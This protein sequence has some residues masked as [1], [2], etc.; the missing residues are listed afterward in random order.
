ME[1]TKFD[2]REAKD[3]NPDLRYIEFFSNEHW[4]SGIEDAINKCV[5]L[6]KLSPKE[7]VEIAWSVIDDISR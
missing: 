6:G 1:N 3:F 2:L 4:L 5:S 7:A